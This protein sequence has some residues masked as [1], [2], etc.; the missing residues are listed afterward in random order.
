LGDERIEP[1]GE[2]EGKEMTPTDR[3]SSS[4]TS[5][6][7][8]SGSFERFPRGR[9]EP[10]ALGLNGCKPKSQFAANLSAVAGLTHSLRRGVRRRAWVKGVKGPS[11]QARAPQRA[12]GG[13]SPCR[14]PGMGTPKQARG[15]LQI[16]KD[17]A[18]SNPKRGGKALP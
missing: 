7:A 1:V 6:A 2:G 12:A 9:N 11:L 5:L 16:K 18:A 13:H 3:L 10:Y 17:Q 4:G 15:P 14:S 8:A